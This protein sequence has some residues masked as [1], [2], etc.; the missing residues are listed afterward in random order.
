MFPRQTPLIH[1]L[2][3]HRLPGL[4][5]TFAIALV[6][7]AA[8]RLSGLAALSPLVLALILGMVLRNTLGPL[9]S[10]S[11]GIHF[12]MKRLL[13]AAIVLLGLQ[14]TFTQVAGLGLHGAV[15]IVLTLTGT[16]VLTKWAGRAL[17]VDR[18]LA[19]LI[20]AGTSV[21]GAS[22]VLATNTVTGG[23]D[24]DVA[25]AIACVAVFGTLSML[26]FPLVGH[27]LALSPQSYGL[28]SGASIHEVAQVIAA[29]FQGGEVAGHAGTVAKL[30]RVILLAPLILTLRAIARRH[31]QGGAGPTP[32]PWFVIGFVAMVAL[33]SVV[34]LPAAL[35]GPVVTLTA[36]MLTMALA[37][38]GLETDL[39]RLRAKG[40]RPLILGAFAWMV[41]S[42][43]GL[44]LVLLG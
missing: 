9:P 37:A 15:T 17:G 31:G 33:N 12:A 11:P 35:Q 4:A 23:T 21:C 5:L 6:A 10:T 25:Y 32:A 14:L 26:G 30:A 39:Q 20:A 43:L 28:W 41:V 40:L 1:P 7:L 34:P 36:L 44:S 13:R 22:A 3:L 16:F 38:M 29:A 27:A 8:Q 2:P 24:E 18:K 19:E 42:A